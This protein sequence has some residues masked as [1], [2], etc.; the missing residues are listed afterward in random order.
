[1][2]TEPMDIILDI[3]SDDQR[4]ITYRPKLRKIAKSVT[5]TILLQQMLHWWKIQGRQPFF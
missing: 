2:K 4:L 3:V 1:M 5:A